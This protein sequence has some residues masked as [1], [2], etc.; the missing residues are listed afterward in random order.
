MRCDQGLQVLEHYT[1]EEQEAQHTFLAE[2]PLIWRI[3][4]VTG[5]ATV[6]FHTLAPIVAVA[7]IAAAMT[8][9]AWP[10]PRCDFCPLLQVQFLSIQV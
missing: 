8:W 1:Q 2:R 7:A 5:V 10:D 9:T 6:L 3:G 4:T